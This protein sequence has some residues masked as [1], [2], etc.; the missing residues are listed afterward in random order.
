MD[1]N[2][3]YA[4]LIINDDPR[5]DHYFK[6][7]LRNSAVFTVLHN[8]N[9]DQIQNREIITSNYDF[10]FQSDNISETFLAEVKTS[11]N[12]TISKNK[13][14]RII[15]Y[16]TK[17]N[18][19]RKKLI[20]C[21]LAGA[22]TFLV[23]PF[24][25]EGLFNACGLNDQSNIKNSSKTRL[26]IAV[27][28]M[29]QDSVEESETPSMVQKITEET[30]QQFQELTSKS[31]SN[32]VISYFSNLKHSSRIGNYELIH[33]KVTEL[34]KETLRSHLGFSKN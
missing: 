24:S 28:M 8:C 26:A 27:K 11:I 18:I 32:N 21:L 3:T 14:P 10:I 4:A 5:K 25:I 1:N 33:K 19:P 6:T 7:F 22:N 17:D 12:K 15:L 30:K 31:L 9:V 23:S 16:S 29:I 20:R 34:V 2:H 13:K